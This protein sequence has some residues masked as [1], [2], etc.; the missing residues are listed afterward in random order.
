MA[1]LIHQARTWST[2]RVELRSQL[3]HPRL[4]GIQYLWGMETAIITQENAKRVIGKPFASGN[5]GRPLGVQ[6]KLS[7]TVR[8]TV[9]EVFNKLQGDP[10]HSLEKFAKDD[11]AEFYKIAAKLIPTELT[12]SIKHI[13]NV[14][15]KEDDE[16][17]EPHNAGD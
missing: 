7:K 13:I 14:T 15:D 4:Q 11:H 3:P 5:P 9:L 17:I 10:D 2:D 6:N 12:G 8:D 1:N 16:S